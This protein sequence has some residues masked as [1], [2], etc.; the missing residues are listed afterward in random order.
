LRRFVSPRCW[1]SGG[2]PPEIF[3][4]PG[5]LNLIAAELTILLAA[6][7]ANGFLAIR[8][9]LERHLR[10]YSISLTKGPKMPPQPAISF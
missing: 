10:R 9:A 6:K 8:R 2:P 1:L 3:L 5:C 7:T 4:I